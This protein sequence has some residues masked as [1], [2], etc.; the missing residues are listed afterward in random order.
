MSQKLN[1]LNLQNFSLSNKEHQQKSETRGQA[2]NPDNIK[3]PAEDTAEIPREV[4]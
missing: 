4:F 2:N 1:T 3:N